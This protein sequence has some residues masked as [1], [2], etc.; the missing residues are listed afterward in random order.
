[1]EKRVIRSD[2][3]SF[4]GVGAGEN[5]AFTRMQGFTELSTSKN[6]K[7]HSVQY[8]DEAHE[9]T[10]VT[11]FSPSMAFTLDRL[12]GNAVHDDIVELFNNE[13]IGTE[14]ERYIV[15]VDFT[16]KNADGSY[17]AIKRK[18]AV[19]GDSEGNGTD[20][21]QY[22]GTFKTAGPSIKG[23]ATIT[24]PEDGNPENVKVITFAESAD[25]ADE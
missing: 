9:T 24:E 2:I 25:A 16:K 15:N 18:F 7:E 13:A 22:S 8:V 10:A 19:I 14:A 11:G 3:K 21:Y 23:S 5:P 17:E 4:Y 1:M 12:D 6:P 20:A